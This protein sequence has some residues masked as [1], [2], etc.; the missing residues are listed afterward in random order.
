MIMN[1]KDI[2]FEIV[3]RTGAGLVYCLYL[4][5]KTSELVLSTSVTNKHAWSMIEA[6]G[7][8]GHCNKY[9]TK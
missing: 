9:A 2:M 1:G 5:L 3:V 4:K 7:R 8:L 6:H